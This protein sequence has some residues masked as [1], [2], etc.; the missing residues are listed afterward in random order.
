MASEI[1]KAL[2]ELQEY[3]D[4]LKAD[5]D[6]TTNY[7]EKEK[8]AGIE[9]IKKA[10]GEGLRIKRDTFQGLIEKLIKEKSPGEVTDS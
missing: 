10:Y 7:I 4:N 1:R 8:A 6:F 9:K 3:I 2:A 5:G